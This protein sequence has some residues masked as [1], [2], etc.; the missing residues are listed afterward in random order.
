MDDFDDFVKIPPH[1][2]HELYSR[3]DNIKKLQANIQN[4][5]RSFRKYVSA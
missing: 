1:H 2:Q 4:T 5:Q 3:L